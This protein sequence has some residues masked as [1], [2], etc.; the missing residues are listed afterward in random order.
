MLLKISVEYYLS[1]LFIIVCRYHAENFE[2][3]AE[4]EIGDEVSE[5]PNIEQ[6]YEQSITK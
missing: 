3:F 4:I 5:P 1:K 6:L 2:N